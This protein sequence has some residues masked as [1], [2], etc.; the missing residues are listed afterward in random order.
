M[1]VR[2]T[3]DGWRLFAMAHEDT[4]HIVPLLQKQ[5]GCDAR[6][7]SATHCQDDPRHTRNCS[8]HAPHAVA[9]AAIRPAFPRDIDGYSVC[10]GTRSVPTT[11]GQ[12]HSSLRAAGPIIRAWKKNT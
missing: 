8:R 10:Y 4:N 5:M 11:L 2:L 7:D 3:E 12:L 1:I 9:V 6:I